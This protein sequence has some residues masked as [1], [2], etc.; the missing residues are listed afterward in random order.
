[1]EKLKEIPLYEFAPRI[2]HLWD[3]QWFL[4][5]SGNYST[6]H[7]NTMTVAWGYFGIMWNKPVAMVVVRPTRY[8]F[9]FMNRYDT[10]TLSGFDKKYKKDLNL[11][12][13]KS[14]RDTNKLAETDLTVIPSHQV[15]AP[16]FREAS[17]VLE[18]KKIYWDDFKQDHFL[19]PSIDRNYPRKD[20]H[21]I[22]FGE[23]LL[24][25][26]TEEYTAINRFR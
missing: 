22:Y 20:Y 19:D 24:I 10:F 8:T 21:R 5:T 2:L 11:L 6:R 9:E 15:D 4:L 25:L 26:G 16:T 13:T 14:G 3:K 23:I 1:M 17:L 7:Y 12:G 18:C